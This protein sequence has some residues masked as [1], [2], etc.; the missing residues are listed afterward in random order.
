MSPT[1][2]LVAV[3][4]VTLTFGAWTT[5]APAHPRVGATAPRFLAQPARSANP[6]PLSRAIITE[7]AC[8]LLTR[9]EVSAALGVAVEKGQPLVPNDPKLCGWAPSG[10]PRI[11]GKKVTLFL[12]TP[13]LH[14]VG[15]T[16]V[17]GIQKT[18]VSGVGDDAYYAITPGLAPGL[19]VKKGSKAF[20]L[21]VGGFPKGK[22]EAIEK[23]LALLAVKRL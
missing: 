20:V 4:T 13:Q 12:T 1:R 3:A 10:G 11:G 8:A 19:N 21:R 5:S 14:D 23:S 6:A 18:P 7:D 9:Q 2:N 15:K 16:P 22:E 17:S